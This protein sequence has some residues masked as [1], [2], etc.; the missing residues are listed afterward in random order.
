MPI[1]KVYYM[2]YPNTKDIPD[3]CRR[4][5]SVSASGAAARFATKLRREMPPNSLNSPFVKT[6]PGIYVIPEMHIVRASN[7]NYKF[8]TLKNVTPDK[9]KWN[10]TIYK[11]R[12]TINFNEPV[13]RTVKKEGKT[14][15]TY[16]PNVFSLNRKNKTSIGNLIPNV[17]KAHAK[18]TSKKRTASTSSKRRNLSTSSKKRRNVSTNSKAFRAAGEQ[19]E[20]MLSSSSSDDDED[21]EQD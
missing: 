17:P 2:Q 18:K 1:G 4:I 10:D 9:V 3:N 21:F 20:T 11:Y 12:I 16:P 15:N 13:K 8:D 14:F 7:S 6:E 5:K 19:D